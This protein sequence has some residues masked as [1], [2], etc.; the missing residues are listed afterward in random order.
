MDIFVFFFEMGRLKCLGAQRGPV[1]GFLGW[2]MCNLGDFN[3]F[4]FFRARGG[5]FFLI[6]I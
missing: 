3:F 4:G 6:H 2:Y 1:Y 5:F